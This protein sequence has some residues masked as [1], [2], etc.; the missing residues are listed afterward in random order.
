[1]KRLLW[2]LST[3]Y[4]KERWKK[5]GLMES[6]EKSKIPPPPPWSYEMLLRVK[7]LPLIYQGTS[8]KS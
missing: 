4:E 7:L 8:K 2:H 6:E 5:K 3:Y 1:M